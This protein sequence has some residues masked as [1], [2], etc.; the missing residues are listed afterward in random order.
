MMVDAHTGNATERVVGT[1]PPIRFG[2][3]RRRPCAGVRV[4]VEQLDNPKP[5]THLLQCAALDADQRNHHAVDSHALVRHAMTTWSPLAA[6][7][8]AATFPIPE[9]APVMITIRFVTSRPHFP[10]TI[11]AYDIHAGSG[12]PTISSSTRV[13]APLRIFVLTQAGQIPK[14]RVGSHPFAKEGPNGAADQRRE[15]LAWMAR[16]HLQGNLQTRKRHS[17]QRRLEIWQHKVLR[18]RPVDVVGGIRFGPEFALLVLGMVL[19]DPSSFPGHTAHSSCLRS[20][21]GL[22]LRSLVCSVPES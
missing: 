12:R 16:S 14:S 4:L 13:Y 6:N 21:S 17:L 15:V 3:P 1:N 11:S 22:V 9:L 10:G 5:A 20:G 2:E 18:L 7:R 19:G 8:C